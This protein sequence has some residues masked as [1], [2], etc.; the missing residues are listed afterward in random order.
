MQQTKQIEVGQR[1]HC[2]LYGGK[3]G[4][5]VQVNGEQSPET[6]STIGRGVCVSGGKAHFD[7]IWDNGTQSFG[8]PES[9]VRGSVQWR[10]IDEVVSAGVV[11]EYRTKLTIETARRTAAEAERQRVFSEERDKLRSQFPKL[12]LAS[13]EPSDFKRGVINIRALL[14]ESFPRVKFSVRQ[15]HYGSVSISW[16][17]GP[18]VKQVEHLVNRFKNGHFDG[19]SDCYE[20]RETPWNSE[21]GGA[22][23]IS[24]SRTETLAIVAKAIDTLWEVLPNVRDLEKPTPDAVFRDRSAIVPHLDAT[25]GELV[26]TLCAFYDATCERFQSAEG[27]YGRLTFIVDYACEKQSAVVAD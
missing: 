12:K 25:V 13:D 1:V 7:I 20:S 24:I 3:D 6:C 16:V 9:L 15:N 22:D 11:A 2:I 26:R 27:W 23:Y 14:K 19:M 10:L 5:I 4:V 8:I 21:F 17:D 18:I